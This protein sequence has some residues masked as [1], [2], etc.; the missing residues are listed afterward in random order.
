[1]TQETSGADR[2]S[3]PRCSVLLVGFDTAAVTSIDE[4]MTAVNWAT[5]IADDG[6]D[7]MQRAQVADFDFVLIDTNGV[8]VFSPVMIEAIRTP[9]SAS[10]RSTIV[11]FADYF[12]PSFKDYLSSFGVDGFYFLPIDKASL[13][14]TLTTAAVTR[15]KPGVHSKPTRRPSVMEDGTD[16]ED[17]S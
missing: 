9:T 14:A 4:V 12:H 8:D 3:R 17:L 13:I 1:M 2:N 5:I 15:I 16:P 10:H 6:D 7:A 11:A